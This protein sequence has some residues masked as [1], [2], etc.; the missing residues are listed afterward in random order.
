MGSLKGG[1][2]EFERREGRVG[3]LKGGRVWSLKG[4]RKGGEFERREGGEFERS[5]ERRNEER[6]QKEGLAERGEG[7]EK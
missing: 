3:S 2:G 1:C 4:G 5:R 6:L 7:G